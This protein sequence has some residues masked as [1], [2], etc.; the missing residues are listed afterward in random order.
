MYSCTAA[1]KNLHP[2]LWIHVKLLTPVPKE[3]WQNTDNSIRGQMRLK[4]TCMEYV[5]IRHPTTLYSS[6]YIEPGF[7]TAT[8]AARWRRI[9]T[10]V[11]NIPIIDDLTNSLSYCPSLSSPVPW[12]AA[13]LS[14]P[15]HMKPPSSGW[16]ASCLHTMF[17]ESLQTSQQ[18]GWLVDH[19][20]LRRIDPP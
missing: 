5:L 19:V 20:S 3:K 10:D 7:L 11:F 12:F 2:S 1:G 9:A 4:S 15:P 6:Q 14:V 13:A 17:P 8:D 16:I 18:R